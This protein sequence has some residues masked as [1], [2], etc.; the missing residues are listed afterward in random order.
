M[1]IGLNLIATNRY[2]YFVPMILDSIE[3]FFFV[4]EEITIFIHTNMD[5]SKIESSKENV[6]IIA[7]EISHEPWPFTT[8]KRFHYFLEAREYLEKCDFLFY[9]DVDSLFIGPLEIP[10]ILEQG[11]FA[12]LHPCLYQGE[13][14]PERNPL[15]TAC[16]PSGVGN[17]YFCGGFF[18][19]RSTEFLDLCD[20]L[21]N[22]IDTDLENEIIAV[23]HDE[24]HLNKYLFENKPSVIFTPPFAVAENLT[25]ET[26]ESK[27]R[28]LDK[29]KL[30]GHGYFRSE[31]NF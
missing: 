2:I 10:M 24:S 13:G 11:I 21:K 7:N 28:F 1:K 9:I 20:T 23:W 18:G 17:S 6:K 16:I 12:T 4:D 15:S 31:D 14:T 25:T 29:K 26:P 8:L 22:N 30:G 5:T 19:G 3:K 27:I